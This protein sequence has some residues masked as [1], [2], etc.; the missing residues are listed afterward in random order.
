MFSLEA[1][2]D[3]KVKKIYTYLYLA[4]IYLIT[5]TAFKAVYIGETGCALRKRMTEHRSDIRHR[6]D[7][8]L[9][10]HFHLSGHLPRVCVLSSAPQDGIRR[11]IIEAQRSARFRESDSLVVLNRD[12]GGD[13][14][15]L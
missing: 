1:H 2:K 13:I 4:V 15:Q 11:H 12:N 14:L 9:A 7:T 8:P 5:C 6:M 3:L 10:E